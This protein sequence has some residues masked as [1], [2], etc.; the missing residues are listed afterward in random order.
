MRDLGLTNPMSTFT[1]QVVGLDVKDGVKYA[2]FDSDNL[3]K[4]LGK[5]KMTKNNV[6]WWDRFSP[7][8]MEMEVPQKF[9]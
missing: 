2:R 7:T 8:I 9:I 5:R 1:N 3:I 4:L 6:K